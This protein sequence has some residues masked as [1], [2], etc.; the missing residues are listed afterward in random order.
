MKYALPGLL[1]CCSTLLLSGLVQANET[2]TLNVTIKTTKQK[3]SPNEARAKLAEN[4]PV[5]PADGGE[6]LK[7][8]NGVT[9]SRFGGR[10]IEPIIRGQSQTQVNV[11]LD[12][13]YLHGGCPNRMDPPTS[14]AA[15]E[16]YEKVTVQK[17]VQ[18]LQNGSGGSGGTV[19]FERDTRAL[20]KP[21]GG[22][23]GK[24]TATT[25]SNGVKHD[26]SAD[27]TAGNQK[28]YVRLFAQDRNADNYKDGDGK[29]VRSSYKHSQGGVVLGVT[30]TENRL[31][32]YSY[33]N[34]DFS[35]ALYPGAGMDSP[36]EQA[37]IH[38]LKYKDKFDG[39]IKSVD[40]EAYISN[41]DHVMDNYSLRTPPPATKMSVP[42]TSDT[43]GGKLALTSTV[44]N[45]T[46]VT[47]GLN[48]QDR[49]R[50]AVMQNKTT[51]KDMFLL[52]PN[53]KTNQ[54]GVFAEAETQLNNNGKLKYGVRYDQVEASADKANVALA[55][56]MSA[57]Q[58]YNTV[59]GTTAKDKTE[60]NV[61][62]LL[63]YE[64]N[65][66]ERTTVFTGASHTVRTADE[67]ERYLNNG[68]W[69]GNPDIKPEKHNQLDL[70]V[71]HKIGKTRLT[72]SVF[73]DKVDDFIL[74]DAKMVNVAGT[75][76]KTTIYRNV[77]ADL[78]GLELGSEAKLNDKLK[79]SGDVAYVRRK[80]TT[81][82]RNIAQ[83]APVIGKV[84][85]DYAATKWGGGTRV[86]F[87]GNQGKLDKASPVEVL[88][89][90]GNPVS[91]GGYAV[92][93][94]YGRYNITKATRV[95]FGV[96]NLFDKTYAEQV[97][98]ANSD[99]AN[100]QA[101]RVNEPG[102]TAW[103]KLETEF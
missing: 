46:E 100:P 12:G 30:P 7:Q 16:S 24:L 19:S 76:T 92:F 85:L 69:T 98:R 42:T 2:D 41:V 99:I 18:T 29:E 32:E 84:Q 53:A 47:Y 102:R 45:H 75:P 40:A 15:L 68:N 60:H 9:G 72:G 83:T 6:F 23:S 3:K 74:R 63:R 26:V 11:L 17:G 43:K 49:T 97:S 96:D 58:R 48:V 20:V 70:G 81:D 93:D 33:E 94:A 78:Y 35:D 90:A 44:G 51:N 65:L 89:K 52:W 67:T 54:T 103:L 50:N 28:G 34:N 62:G 36:T 13:A 37:D 91:A 55:N 64:K 79:V 88:D 5:L 80:N 57:N 86:R 66:N 73:A 39:A 95:R 21:E 101:I 82:N 38:R 10:G 59:Y 61:G 4:T 27:V 22:L 56:G 1:L 77:D 8:L 14:Y 31:I 25:M 71:S 87:A